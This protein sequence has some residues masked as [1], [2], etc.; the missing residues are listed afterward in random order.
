MNAGVEI[1]FLEPSD[2]ISDGTLF[3]V[4]YE[5]SLYSFFFFLIRRFSLWFNKNLT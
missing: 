4:G 5:R 2:K 3:T 1:I